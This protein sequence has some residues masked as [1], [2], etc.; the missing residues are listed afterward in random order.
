MLERGIEPPKNLEV[1]P[2]SKLF[3]WLM[4]LWGMF[5]KV[6]TFTVTIDPASVAANTTAE[7]TF[8]VTGL[9]TQ[10]IITVTK[11][12]HTTGLGIVNAR[13]SA[14]DVLA[15][16]YINCTG[17]PIDAGSESYLVASIRR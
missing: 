12:S 17:S 8:T 15:I 13:A 5:P 9:R 10:D 2:S 11:P 7:Q 16:T 4:N 14:S 3:K 1:D 6:Q